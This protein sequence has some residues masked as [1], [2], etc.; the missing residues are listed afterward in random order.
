MAKKND[1]P[2]SE[3][4]NLTEQEAA[5]IIE[6]FLMHDA[7]STEYEVGLILTLLRALALNNDGLK[8]DNLLNAVENKLMP[9]A[10]TA[11]RAIDTLCDKTMRSVRKELE[12]NG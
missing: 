4:Y 9:Y 1:T 10:F 5:A 7:F 8:R 12:V 2:F 11:C 6:H 3:R